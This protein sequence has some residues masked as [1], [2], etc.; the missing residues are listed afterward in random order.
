MT[1]YIERNVAIS[2]I[3][4]KESDIYFDYNEGLIEAMNVV[5]DL[6]SADV[7]ERCRWIP[8]TELLPPE[9]VTVLICTEGYDT[10]F[11]SFATTAIWTGEQWLSGWDHKS[12]IVDVTYWMPLPEPP[13]EK[14]N[15]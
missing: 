5:F 10:D 4:E 13:K 1:D 12:E 3:K 2:A 9:G 14:E 11:L 6:P 7:V 8:V 15:G